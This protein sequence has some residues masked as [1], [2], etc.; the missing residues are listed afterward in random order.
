MDQSIIVFDTETTGLP[1]SKIINSETLH[2]WPHVVQFSYVMY[3]VGQM[4]MEKV[5]DV[6]VKIPETIVMSEETMNIHKITN[7][8]TQ[9]SPFTIEDVLNEFIEDISCNN[10]TAIVGHN[11][12]FDMNML[13][14]EL[15][16]LIQNNDIIDK[17]IYKKMFYEVNYTNKTYCTMK[18]SIDL[19]QI[20]LRRKDGTVYYK[21]PKLIELY[22]KIFDEEPNNLHNSLN[23][24][25]VT[26]R[27][28][29]MMVFKEDLLKVDESTFKLLF[30]IKV[31]NM[32]V[33]YK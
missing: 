21:Y 18:K 12:S 10:V 25:L 1:R 26:L 30:E 20:P 31:N 33:V 14:I 13:K 16:R 8:Q 22:K 19:C 24:V 27:C 9:G 7:E 32:E 15:L 5:K 2:L 23:D 6:V 4:K 11:I 3:N 29:Y 17:S 28:Y